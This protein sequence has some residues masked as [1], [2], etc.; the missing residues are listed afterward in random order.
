MKHLFKFAIC[1]LSAVCLFLLV[2]C[3]KHEHLYAQTVFEPTCTERGYTLYS[4]SCG[5]SYKDNYVNAKGH[6][7]VDHYCTEC[8]AA[9]PPHSLED[10]QFF[11]EKEMISSAKGFNQDN[12]VLTYHYTVCILNAI[13]TAE[14]MQFYQ[15]TPALLP[16]QIERGLFVKC[17]A[18]LQATQQVAFTNYYNFGLQLNSEFER[19]NVSTT[20]E[21]PDGTFTDSWFLLPLTENSKVYFEFSIID[22]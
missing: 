7:Y 20:I 4:C 2:S 8:S 22:S 15:I 19:L 18:V 3:D 17:E 21:L 10:L 13:E 11:Y 16:A 12:E 9:Q 14:F 5:D 6:N 1:F